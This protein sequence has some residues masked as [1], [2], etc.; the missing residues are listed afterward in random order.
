MYTYKYGGQNGT[1]YQLVE[2]KDLVVVRTE[3]DVELRQMNLSQTS[4]SLLPGLI[5]VAAFPEA[6]VTIYR[7]VDKREDVSAESLRNTVRRSLNTEDGIR[8][9]GRVL[10]DTKTGALF[11]YTENFFLKF[12][13][14]VKKERCEEIIKKLDLEIKEMLPFAPNSYFLEAK[15]GTGSNVFEIANTCLDM[16]E[17]EYCHPE[18]VQPIKH[19]NIH[20]MQWHLARTNINGQTIDQHVNV[21]AAWNTTRGA[22]TIIAVIDDGF[23]VLH[24][25]F[26]SPGKVVAQRDTILNINDARPKRTREIHGTACAGVACANGTNKAVGVAPDAR[27]MPIRFGG[28]GSMA[29]AKAFIW[30]ADNG[31]D[32]ISCSWGP[33]DGDWWNPNDPLHFNRYDLPDSSRLAIEYA[34]S[35]GRNGKGCVIVWAA[36]NGNENLGFDGYASYPKVMAVAACNDRGRRSVYSDFGNAV[37]CCFPSSDFF[38]P[39]LNHPRPLS[40][41]IWTTDRSGNQGYN[42]GGINSESTVGDFEGNYTATFGGTSSSCPGVAGVVALVLSINPELTWGEVKEII[43]NSCDQIDGNFGNYDAQGHSPFYGYGRINAEKAVLNAKA[44]LEKEEILDVKGLGHFKEIEMINL[45][46]DQWAIS[47]ESGDRLLGLQLEIAP[48][49]PDLGIRYQ[50]AINNLGLA[51][52][53]LNGSFTGTTDRR[54][55]LIGFKVELIGALSDRYD[56]VYSGRFG[57]DDQVLSAK[58]G[59]FCGESSGRG[60]ALEGLRVTVVKR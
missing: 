37:W 38:V 47:G 48:F 5:P 8:F 26:N 24:E 57:S 33:A 13:D 15:E 25:E 19:K 40:P 55:K 17:V 2:A 16:K 42:D 32:V 43:K 7:C 12:K 39:Q 35:N 10:K 9:A 18:L 46:D 30:A 50:V 51:E 49:M 3:E 52:E 36:G 14:E 45:L 22:D 54:R 4:R 41:G 21:E 58:N 56:V 34:I 31:A 28:L 11:V 53:A 27:L 6:N 60:D 20:P 23:D 29:E 44:T 59:A 1:T